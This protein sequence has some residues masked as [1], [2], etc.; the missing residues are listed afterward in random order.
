MQAAFAHGQSSGTAVTFEQ[1]ADRWVR[2]REE[3]TARPDTSRRAAYN[4]ARARYREHLHRLYPEAAVAPDSL[5][6]AP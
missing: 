5:P 4:Q 2:V 6:L 1:L 3:R